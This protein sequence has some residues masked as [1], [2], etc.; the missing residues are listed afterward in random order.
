MD[1]TLLDISMAEERSLVFKAS[2]DATGV[3]E[4]LEDIGT[5]A[6]KT[7]ST[8]SGAFAM[9][10]KQLG[11]IPSK[12]KGIAAGFK[13]A[14]GGVKV[15][16]LALKASPIFLL[17]GVIMS[18]VQAFRASEEGQNK[19]NKAMLVINTTVDNFLDLF[20]DVGELI[21]AAFEN[22]VDTIKNL[23][24]LLVDNVVNRITGIIKLFPRLGEAIQLAFKGD[25][26]AAGKVAV[27]AVAQVATG[28]EDFSDKAV[29]AYESATEAVAEF[30]EKLVEEGNQA[31]KVADMRAK[32]DLIE[33]ELLVDRAKIE[34]EMAD[35]R[36]KSREEDKYTADERLK[37]LQDAQ[38]LE[39]ELLD[40]EVEALTLRRDAQSLQNTF[41]RSNKEALD[42]EAQAAA[43]VEQV[44][45]RRLTSQ[46]A[47]QREVNRLNLEIERN[48]KEAEKATTDAAK[49][50]EERLKVL[51]KANNDLYAAQDKQTQELEKIFEEAQTQEELAVMRKYDNIALFAEEHG[52]TMAEV[53]AKQEE[54][55]AAIQKKY[56][57]AEV[58][59]NKKKNDKKAADDQKAR[60]RNMQM[61]NNAFGALIALNNAFSKDTEAGAK[62][63]F[64]RNKKFQT[65]QAIIQTGM[66]VTAALTAGGNPIKLATGA[67][68]V[69]AGIAAAMGAAQV[70]TIQKTK[71]DSGGV[72]AMPGMIQ[73]GGQ[74]QQG[75]QP[76][77]VGQFGFG[78]TSGS[79]MTRSYV[80][81][82]EVTSQQQAIQ[83]VNDQASLNQGG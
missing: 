59:E 63:Q 7:Q 8:T 48:A 42:A 22:P 77:S 35:A 6:K 75:P 40:R 12:L 11:G 71:F 41:A 57:D 37:F 23:G 49:A 79:S 62:A 55:L 25:F 2:L 58:A 44:Q 52:Y 39:D 51:I 20:A 66:A 32:A 82:Q 60:M 76:P 28:V 1:R 67:Q 29:S 56:N 50:E 26:A 31:A 69:E 34:A 65:A 45:A 61:A 36:L 46:R 5:T 24:K 14:G 21:I 3:E 68:F 70:A 64:E 16:N 15:M 38:R 83:L 54:E 81:G 73:G 10:D 47:V 19:F 43:A 78:A 9:L 53:I 80:V 74:G 13:G 4:G 33:R 17:V 72:P 27:D 18:I 30:G